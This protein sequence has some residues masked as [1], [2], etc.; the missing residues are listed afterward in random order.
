[1]VFK[2]QYGIGQ[3]VMKL[4]SSSKLIRK[5]DISDMFFQNTVK[6]KVFFFFKWENE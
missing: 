5:H 2:L 4:C 1:M 6:I 3:F